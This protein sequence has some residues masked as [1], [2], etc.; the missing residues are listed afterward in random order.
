MGTETYRDFEIGPA[1]LVPP[2][3]T[4]RQFQFT[5]T[6]KDYDGAPDAY[7]P[8]FFHGASIEAVKAM[9]DEWWATEAEAA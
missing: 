6:H 8:R 9:V 1:R 7:D 4:W 3:P 2:I 5:A